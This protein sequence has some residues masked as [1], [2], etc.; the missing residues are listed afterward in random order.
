M[1]KFYKLENEEWRIACKFLRPTE[2]LILYHLRTLDP[3]GESEIELGVSSLARE[4]GVSKGAVSKALRSLAEK[5]WIDLELNN[6]NVRLKSFPHENTV[7][8]RKHP[9]EEIGVSDRFHTET[10]FP[11]ENDRSRTETIVSTRKHLEPETLTEQEVC[12]A[13]TLKT[14]KDLSQESAI[15]FS[16]NAEPLPLEQPPSEELI[17]FVISQIGKGAN[18]PRAYAKTA[19]QND[20]EYWQAEFEKSKQPVER[21]QTMPLIA[22]AFGVRKEAPPIEVVNDRE[23][24]LARAAGILE[25]GK[26]PSMAKFAQQRLKKMIDD[27]SITPEELKAYLRQKTGESENTC[28]VVHPM[29]VPHLAGVDVLGEYADRCKAAQWKHFTDLEF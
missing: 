18:N 26:S 3:F 20:R 9:N 2:L 21:P 8:T 1:S 25:M 23:A 11:H 17:G 27:Y 19:I 10:P 13:K 28:E 14:L 29:E 15:D 4:L 5:G 6:V 16:E 22:E 12:N 24:I 7:S